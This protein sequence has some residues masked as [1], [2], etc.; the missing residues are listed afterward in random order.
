MSNESQP[1]NAAVETS[2]DHSTLDMKA[3]TEMTPC[4][5]KEI[6]RM[7]HLAWPV[8]LAYQLETL[9]GPICVALVGHLQG[10]DVSVLVDAAYM[11]ATVTNVTAL[12][13][14]FGLASAMDT[15][16]S[17][18]YGAGKMDKLGIYFQS[19]LI[20]LGVALVPISLLSWHAESVLLFFG[21]DPAISKYAGQFSRVTIFGIPF[22]FVYE[23]IKKLQ[24]SQNIVLPMMY[25]ACVGVVVNVVTGF[26]LTYYTSWGFLGAAVGRVCGSVALPLTIVAY[27]HYDHATTSTWWRGFQWRDACSHVGLFLSLGVPSMTMLAVSWWAFCALG[28]LAGILPNSVHAVSVNAVLGQLLTLNF[29]IYLGISVASNVLIG[30]ALGA[31]QPQRARLIARLGLT[32]GGISAAIMASLFLVGRHAIPY[33]FVSDPLTIEYGRLLGGLSG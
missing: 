20:V 32:A 30:N 27:F 1:L 15:L 25:V 2:V 8:F 4:V 22:L 7:F 24:Q 33:L 21:Q 10:D 11:S 6:S 26:C 29:M 23:L 3:E 9:P 17:Q 14:G 28:F 5:R 13:I 16:C 12:A 31:N 18:A 19:G